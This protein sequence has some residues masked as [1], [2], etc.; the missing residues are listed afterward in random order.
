MG[1]EGGD[2]EFLLH[3]INRYRIGIATGQHINVP[4]DY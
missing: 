1:E 3:C 4:L 2:P